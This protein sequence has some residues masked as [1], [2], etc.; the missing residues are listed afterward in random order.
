MS[1]APSGARLPIS[2]PFARTLVA[3]ALVAALAGC[4]TH[5]PRIALD[6]VAWR[7]SARIELIYVE[8]AAPTVAYLP[9][10]DPAANAG[11]LQALA[12][13]DAA[14]DPGDCAR[15]A[16]PANVAQRANPHRAA[17]AW[18]IR[19][20]RAAPRDFAARLA[21]E[22]FDTVFLQVDAQLESDEPL[23]SALAAAGLR[24]IA[25][26]GYPDA[27]EHPQALER[28]IELIRRYNTTHTARIAGFQVDVEPYLLPGFRL[29]AEAGFGHYLVLLRS[30]RA[31]LGPDLEFSAAIPFWYA[32]ERVAGRNL[33]AEVIGVTDSVAVMS[34]RTTRA[35]VEEFSRPLLCLAARH[36][37][38]A[39]VGLELAPLK[40]EVHLVLDAASLGRRVR[41]EGGRLVLV[42]GDGLPVASSYSVKAADLSFSGNP[43][44]L[45]GLIATPLPHAGFAGWAINGLSMDGDGG[46]FR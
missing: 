26:D 39:W 12:Q 29:D 21:G 23:V 36:G 37:R 42:A 11:E 10:P 33:A 19:A 14:D 17:W 4:A 24:V 9:A 46:L 2:S 31:Q 16:Q 35:Q 28:D 32:G 38:T 5:A 41:R 7:R 6:E 3:A 15:Q 13:Q 1:A 25:L 27:A 30:L 34:Y 43:Q 18:D 44:G 22:G 40:S 8:G 20:A 45:R